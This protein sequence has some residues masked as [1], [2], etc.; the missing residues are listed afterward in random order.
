MPQPGN[1]SDEG[2]GRANSL[3]ECQSKTVHYDELVAPT[4]G[5]ACASGN[6]ECLSLATQATKESDVRTACQSANPRLCT[7]TSWSLRRLEQLAHLATMNASAWQRKRRRSRTCEQL[8][9]VPIQ[10]CAL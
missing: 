9:R 7:M 8:V 10:D 4:T 5:A 3:S 2:V 6:D 1:A